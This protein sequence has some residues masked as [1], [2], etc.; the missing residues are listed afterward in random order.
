MAKPTAFF[1]HS[2]A[3]KRPLGKLKELFVAKTGGS[4]EVFLSSDGQSI[5]FGRNW[6]HGVEQALQDAKLMFVFVTPH[7]LRS[8]W[9]HFESG[10]AY[11]KGIQVIPVGLG[12]D[13]TSV[14]AP[15]NLLQGFN[16]T[17]EAGL[18]NLIAVVNE[19][20][21]HSH[22]ESFASDDLYLISA[23]DEFSVTTTLGPHTAA[24]QEMTIEIQKEHL[25][26]FSANAA[27][28]VMT[29]YLDEQKVEHTLK[30]KSVRT[31]GMTIH[32]HQGNGP[33]KLVITLD[34]AVFDVAIPLIDSLTNQMSD[35]GMTGIQIRF[36]FVKD[37]TGVE[38]QHS[39]SGKLFGSGVKL[40]GEDLLSF[41]NL[42]FRVGHLRRFTQHTVHRG[43]TYLSIQ[44][45][46]KT[47]ALNEVR[48][49]MD[50]LFERGV[51]FFSEER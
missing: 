10:Y 30:D 41:R 40:S 28:Q 23:G 33:D 47:L 15:L 42:E 11:S 13:L 18:N 51:L 25:G 32:A 3:D 43:A 12:A 49:L 22:P 39:L 24:I 45:R 6:V 21:G 38:K 17:S 44:T 4:I 5:P 29:T 35:S 34:P 2:S 20:F 9:L 31:Q 46:N 14:G 7:S 8:N 19:A 26:E 16:V 37:V 50:L 27:L 36:D 1:S 48:A